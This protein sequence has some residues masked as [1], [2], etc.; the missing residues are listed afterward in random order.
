MTKDARRAHVIGLLVNIALAALKLTVGFLA[1]SEALT[2]DGFNS[3][4]DILATAI[5]FAGFMYALKPPDDDH[6]YGH[7]NA[8]SVA[9]LVI[10][11]MLLATGAF[12][13]LHGMMAVFE[14][15]RDPPGEMALYAAL[16]TMAIKETLYRYTE[17]IGRRFNSPSLLAS[18]RDHR[19]DVVLSLTVAAGIFFARIGSPILDPIAAGLVGIYVAWLAIEPIR[20]NFATLMDQAP[21]GMRAAVRETAMSDPDVL[22]VEQIRVHPLGSYY[23]VDF[24]I[25][26]DGTLTVLV[27]HE[28]AHRVAEAVRSAVDHVQ[29]VNVHVNPAETGNA[30]G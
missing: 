28:I 13:F 3:A 25:C 14:G 18:A 24:E 4:G 12:I 21:P 6:H 1:A 27:S 9:G 10:G 5:G 19:A 15:R 22:A 20:S 7:G 29:S 17:R 8:E 16:A 30:H 26:V 23:M 2:A 11:A